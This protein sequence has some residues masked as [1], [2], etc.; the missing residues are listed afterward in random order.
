LFHQSVIRLNN[1]FTKENPYD[2]LEATITGNII[3]ANSAIAG[4]STEYA[5]LGAPPYTISNNTL[6][7]AKLKLR[8]ED[9]ALNNLELTK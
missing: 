6:Y 5:G 9:I 7:N 8:L 1:Y 3:Y 4:I 2:V